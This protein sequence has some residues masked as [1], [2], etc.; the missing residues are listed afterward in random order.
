LLWFVTAG[1]EANVYSYEES[2]DLRD[3]LLTLLSEQLGVEKE[4]LTA[5]PALVN[6]LG[7]DSLD[8]VELVMEL[9]ESLDS[10]G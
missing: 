9:E 5:N 2:A 7:V 4:R 1:T 6:D 10:S 8:M 3:R